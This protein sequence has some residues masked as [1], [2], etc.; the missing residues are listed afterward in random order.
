[1]MMPMFVITFFII[2]W[3]FTLNSTHS[4]TPMHTHTHTHPYFQP[5]YVWTSKYK[6]RC[7]RLHAP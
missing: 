1:M 3:N 4:P 5:I 6:L 2:S 7:A